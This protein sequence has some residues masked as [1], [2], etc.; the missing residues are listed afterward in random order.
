MDI[1]ARFEK[2]RNPWSDLTNKN[3]RP[4][5]EFMIAYWPTVCSF[6]NLGETRDMKF[7]PVESEG[8]ILGQP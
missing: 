6:I 2:K 7:Q 5:N 3:S 4:I 8:R 1:F